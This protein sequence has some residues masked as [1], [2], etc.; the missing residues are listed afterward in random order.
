MGPNVESWARELNAIGISTFALDG[1]TGRGLASVNTD[2][3]LLGRL[4]FTLDAYRVLDMLAKHP[5]V[6]PARIC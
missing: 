3:A 6:D 4:A 2:Q 1:F 5:R